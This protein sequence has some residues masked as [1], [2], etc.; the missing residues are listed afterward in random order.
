MQTVVLVACGL[1]TCL[2]CLGAFLLQS[3]HLYDLFLSVPA[4][5]EEATTGLPPPS[6]LQLWP[7]ALEDAQPAGHNGTSCVCGRLFYRDLPRQPTKAE[8]PIVLTVSSTMNAVG[9]FLCAWYACATVNW[10]ARCHKHEA[11]MPNSRRGSTPLI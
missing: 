2:C 4:C 8:V 3:R 11:A 6:D 5:R 7:D 1:A 10:L 9:A